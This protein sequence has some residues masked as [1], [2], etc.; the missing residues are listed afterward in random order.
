MKFIKQVLKA[1]KRKINE[2]IFQDASYREINT[3]LAKNQVEN[4][5][6]ESFND[7]DVFE[8]KR[9]LN[10]PNKILYTSNILFLFNRLSIKKFGRLYA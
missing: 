3:N 4:L 10:L 7:V 9:I 5:L 2:N 6:W 1:K 8:F